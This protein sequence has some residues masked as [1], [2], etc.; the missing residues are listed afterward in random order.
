MENAL[1]QI[2]IWRLGDEW[3][4][5]DPSGTLGRD[6]D[7][8]DAAVWLQCFANVAWSD[9]PFVVLTNHNEGPKFSAFRRELVMRLRNVGFLERTLQAITLQATVVSATGCVRTDRIVADGI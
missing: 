5:N 4:G 3:Q 1:R 6:G 9:Q 7:K 8:P 2:T